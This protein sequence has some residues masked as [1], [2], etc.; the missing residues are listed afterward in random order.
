VEG[1][2]ELYGE[3]LGTNTR[4]LDMCRSLGFDI[5][6]DPDDPSLFR[7]RLTLPG[8]LYAD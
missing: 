5:A 8:K 6:A 4:M 3:V 1:L 7:A 2:H